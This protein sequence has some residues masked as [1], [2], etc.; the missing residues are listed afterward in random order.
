[1]T[2]MDEGTVDFAGLDREDN[3]LVLTISDHLPWGEETDDV[4]L[5]FL[6]NKINDYLRF[7][8]SGEVNEAFKPEDY[9]KIVISIVSKFPFSPD[10]IKFLNMSKQVIDNAGFGLQWEVL[11]AGDGSGQECLG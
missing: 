1:M 7:I 3:T 4:H 9:S 11:P 10:C 2:V 6:Q 5:L 8:E